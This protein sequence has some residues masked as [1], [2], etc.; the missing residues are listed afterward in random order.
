MGIDVTGL[1]DELRN[2]KDIMNN[3]KEIEIEMA[4]NKLNLGPK[5]DILLKLCSKGLTKFTE[6]KMMNKMKEIQKGDST[7]SAMDK[8]NTKPLNSELKDKYSDI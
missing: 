5:S 3:L 2:D 8:L 1:S 4:G 6:N 7:K